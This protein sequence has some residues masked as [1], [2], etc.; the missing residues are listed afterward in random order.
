MRNVRVNEG[1]VIRRQAEAGRLKIW[2]NMR[3]DRR[4]SVRKWMSR[5]FN[6]L[7]LA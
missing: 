4:R 6:Q 2:P 7:R 3:R 5:W 1:K